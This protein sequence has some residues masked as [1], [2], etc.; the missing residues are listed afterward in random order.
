LLFLFLY[1][2]GLNLLYHEH[3]CV[4]LVLCSISYGTT[5]DKYVS[6]CLELNN[7]LCVLTDAVW[8]I[9]TYSCLKTWQLQLFYY[10]TNY[11][12]ILSMY[13]YDIPHTM[14]L[15]LTTINREWQSELIFIS[16]EPITCA[17]F[18]KAIA[19][20]GSKQC[21]LHMSLP[22]EGSWLL[23]H[24]GGNIIHIHAVYVHVVG[25]LLK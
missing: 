13:T 14:L 5:G 7:K 20:L 11:L 21:K 25:C 18:T 22:D 8:N 12:H 9:F 4:Y 6:V 17:I 3:V 10:K 19:S 15:R 16:Q 1:L 2:F 23:K 24:V